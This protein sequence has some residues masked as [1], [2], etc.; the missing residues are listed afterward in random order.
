MRKQRAVSISYLKN[1]LRNDVTTPPG[2][3]V[4]LSD[5]HYVTANSSTL[6]HDVFVLRQRHYVRANNSELD[7]N[8][9]RGLRSFSICHFQVNMNFELGLSQFSQFGCS[10]Y[11]EYKELQNKSFAFNC[12]DLN[13]S[14]LCKALDDFKTDI[15][16]TSINEVRSESFDWSKHKNV[17]TSSN[18]CVVA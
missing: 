3:R 16:Q 18:R 6:D 7:Q 17:P 2:I 9:L 15:N 8:I 10:Q 14:D 4:Q 12:D 13:E 1:T 5:M 11:E